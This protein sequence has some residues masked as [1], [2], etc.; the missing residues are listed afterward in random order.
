MN[1]FEKEKIVPLFFCQSQ[2]QRR[3]KVFSCESAADPT[4]SGKASF[5]NQDE[6]L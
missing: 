6:W 5:S 2:D 3:K 1:V 4:S